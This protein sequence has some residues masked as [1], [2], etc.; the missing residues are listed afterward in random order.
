MFFF[1]EYTGNVTYS[2][3]KALSQSGEEKYIEHGPVGPT[4]MSTDHR[5]AKK[6]VPHETG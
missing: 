6:L 1:F 4:T 5:T 3:F 2:I